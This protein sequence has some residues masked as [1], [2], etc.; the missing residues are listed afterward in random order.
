MAKIDRRIFIR[1]LPLF[2]AGISLPY[3]AVSKIKKSSAKI[4]LLFIMTDQ[5]R[6]DT[7]SYGGTPIIKTPNLDRLAKEG[8]YFENAYSNCPICVPTRVVIFTG[9]STHSSGVR[10]NNELK[11]KNLPDLPT[12]DS[13]LSENRY[14]TEY[15][16]KWHAPKKFASTYKYIKMNRDLTE[17]GTYRRYLD[18]HVPARSL[19]D[20][21]L[22]EKRTRRAYTPIPLDPNYKSAFSR[23]GGKKN[24]KSSQSDTYG[25]LNIPAEHCQTAFTAK[26]ILQALKRCGKKKPFS[27]TCSI[28]PPHPP[29][30]I[31]EPYFSMYDLE[32]MVVPPSINDKLDN[33]PYA[34]KEKYAKSNPYRNAKN[35]RQMTTIYYG[36]ISNL[37]YWVGRILDELKKMKM[38]KNTLVIFTSDHGEMLGDH[39][40]HGKVKMYEGAA[41]IPL[42]M[43]MPK[44]IRKG[45]RISTPV[46]HVDL[47]S[48]ILDYLDIPEHPSEGRSLRK[49]IDGKKDPVDFSVSEWKELS[50]AMIR[51]KNWKLILYSSK[52]MKR[53]SMNALYD[54]KDD[55][56]EMNNLIAGDT[57]RKKYSKIL[58]AIKKRLVKWC[59]KIHHPQLES[60]KKIKL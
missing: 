13:I 57:G 59:E 5:Q 11:K 37:D 60:I 12:F 4:N 40:M 1:T 21:E 44:V 47:F 8:A 14:H 3:K 23:S 55:P 34:I 41:H 49:L 16:G 32:K 26:E 39:G 18:K 43:R 36:I 20:N 46:S 25:R 51:V 45:A 42:I 56:H 33:A 50:P 30:V 29:M 31:P 9:H 19:K 52:K 54:L 10:G 28:D 38:E 27:I 48:T 35:I 6:W 53:G 2:V 58:E 17:T 24:G 22:L 7:I 15:Y